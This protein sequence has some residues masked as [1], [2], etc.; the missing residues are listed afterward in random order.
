MR[1]PGQPGSRTVLGKSNNSDSTVPA[2]K[3]LGYNEE[4]CILKGGPKTVPD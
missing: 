2:V 4:S 1:E 3:Q